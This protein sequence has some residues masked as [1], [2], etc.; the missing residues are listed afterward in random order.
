MKLLSKMKE[1]K[2]EHIEKFCDV[3]IDIQ[4]NLSKEFKYIDMSCFKMKNVI[5]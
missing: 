1:I 5:K 2:Y 3:L 4:N